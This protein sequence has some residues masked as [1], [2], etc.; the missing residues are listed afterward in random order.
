MAH[1][2]DRAAIMPKN[3]T[4]PKEIAAFSD[5]IPVYTLVYTLCYILVK[6]LR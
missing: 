4:I 2:A 6:T 3:G 1:K 5:N